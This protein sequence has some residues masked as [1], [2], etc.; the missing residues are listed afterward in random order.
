L[1]L[2]SGRTKHLRADIGR[3]DQRLATLEAHTPAPGAN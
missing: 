3:I 2:L 1:E